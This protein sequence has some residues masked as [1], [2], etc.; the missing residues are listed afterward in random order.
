MKILPEKILVFIQFDQAE[1]NVGQIIR[2]NQNYYFRYS[3][4]YLKT[5][6]NISPYKLRFDNSIQK[7]DVAFFEGLFGVF[8]DSQPD[9]WGRLLMDRFLMNTG[10]S[11][12]EIDP[13]LRLSL[14]GMNG[15]GALGYKPV[16][17]ETGEDII[18]S[19]LDQIYKK[20]LDVYDD[21]FDDIDEIFGLAGSSGGARPKIWIN[22]NEATDTLNKKF[23]LGSQPWIIKFPSSQDIKGIALVE[24]VY[25]QMAQQTGITMSTSKLFFGNS[26]TP[27]FGTKRFDIADNKRFHIIS[28]AGLLDDN[29]RMTALDYGHIMD[30]AFTLTKN[31][32]VYEDVLRLGIFNVL[33]NNKDDHS[34]N[35]SFL[36][37]SNGNWSFSPAY[38]LTYSSSSHGYQST[39]VDGESKRIQ[40]KHFDSLATLFGVSNLEVIVEQVIDSLNGFK[41]LAKNTK[42]PVTTLN[43]IQSS[44]TKNVNIFF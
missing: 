1:K 23:E 17:K 13:L 39:T 24:Y 41:E 42:M 43:T 40:Y 37:D 4:E 30:A 5:G 44:I 27:Y 20:S 18:F 12:N 22:Y 10:W 21:K 9:G 16:F 38:D 15:I 26:G 36:M 2:D 32:K 8:A 14:V 19:D 34:K 33:S 25:H 6:F 11:M 3:D 35:F 31:I 7:T 28:A 29:Y